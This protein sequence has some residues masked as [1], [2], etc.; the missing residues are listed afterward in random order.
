MRSYLIVE[1]FSD[2][3]QAIGKVSLQRLSREIV[4]DC[5]IYDITDGE[6]YLGSLSH[7]KLVYILLSLTIQ[8]I[9][10]ITSEINPEAE[11]CIQLCERWLEDPKS[12]SKEESRT[13]A[14]AAQ[15]I[16]DKPPIIR[17]VL[18][19]ALSCRI[20]CLYLAR[21]NDYWDYAVEF[22]THN[23]NSA[24]QQKIINDRKDGWK[25]GYGDFDSVRILEIDN[26]YSKQGEVIIDFL[27]SDKY[28]F[29][30]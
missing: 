5:E 29:M 4:R 17:N 12:I 20:C 14:H 16:L 22:I 9:K 10:A 6:I 1:K 27:K 25:D 28:L 21:N 24:L 7:K 13:A 2:G 11:L 23:T 18:S 3:T 30:V 8:A 19:R 26:E 15:D